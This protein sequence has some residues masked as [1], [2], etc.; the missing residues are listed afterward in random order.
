[1]N[2]SLTFKKTILLTVQVINTSD[3]MRQRNEIVIQIFDF[4]K[5]M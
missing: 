5:S 2:D 3:N 1:M 4:V